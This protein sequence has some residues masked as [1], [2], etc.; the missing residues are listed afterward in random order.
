[1]LLRPSTKQR[2]HIIS[3]QPLMLLFIAHIIALEKQFLLS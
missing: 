1:M 3:S 2:L